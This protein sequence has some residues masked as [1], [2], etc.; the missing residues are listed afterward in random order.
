MLVS[1]LY[2][3]KNKLR[4]IGFDNYKVQK[5]QWDALSNTTTNIV[6]KRSGTLIENERRR[7]V[8]QLE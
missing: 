8:A 6:N 5:R 7:S 1:K 3:G 4:E 2:T